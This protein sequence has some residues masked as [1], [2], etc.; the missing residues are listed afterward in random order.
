VT[1]QAWYRDFAGDAVRRA[2]VTPSDERPGNRSPFG[3]LDM[4]GNC[5]EWT[6][7]TLDDPAEAVI[8]GGSYDNPMRAVQA[9]SKGVY[10]KRGGSNAVGFR[11][12]QDIDQADPRA[13]ARTTG[14]TESEGPAA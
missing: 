10:R 7:T 9:S 6:S 14:T 13:M 8:C 4:V 3:V 11:C 2:G 5:W 12:V 1:Y